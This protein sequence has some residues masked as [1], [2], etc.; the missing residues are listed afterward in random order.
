MK[1]LKYKILLALFLLS[2]ASSLILSLTPISE[3]CDP[4]KGCDVVHYSPYNFTFGI[5]NSYYGVVIFLALSLF[6]FSY[7]KKPDKNKK[8]LIH[9][10]VIIASIIALYFLYV[11]HFVLNS[12]CKY[13]LIVD[14][15]MI[16]ALMV[17]LIW[18]KE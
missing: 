16:I 2:L 8:L 13:C 15:S 6:T 7:M 5:Q 11:Q 10:A 4:N 3:I 14:F 18:W 1:N 17:T 9:L 12:Y